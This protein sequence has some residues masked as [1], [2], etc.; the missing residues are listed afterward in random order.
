MISDEKLTKLLLKTYKEGMGFGIE[1]EKGGKDL[2]PLAIHVCAQMSVQ[3]ILNDIKEELDDFDKTIKLLH[4]ST[5][6]KKLREA[7]LLVQEYKTK[8]ITK[9]E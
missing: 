7:I 1:L 9:D 8:Y 2:L 3:H 6:D 5:H 4:E